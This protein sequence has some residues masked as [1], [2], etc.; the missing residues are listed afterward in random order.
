MARAIFA[1]VSASRAFY[2]SP[3]SAGKLFFLE[4]LLGGADVAIV[5]SF[6]RKIVVMPEESF[7]AIMEASDDL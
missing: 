5:Q 4:R 2:G 3:V 6:N 1:P 7:N